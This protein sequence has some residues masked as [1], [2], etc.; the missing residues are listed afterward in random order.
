MPASG[1]VQHWL[2]VSLSGGPQRDCG[3]ASAG[4]GAERTFLGTIRLDLPVDTLCICTGP[5]ILTLYGNPKA[6]RCQQ[7]H[8]QFV[9]RHI[10]ERRCSVS[11]SECSS[12]GRSISI[13]ICSS[14]AGFFRDSAGVY[15]QYG[16][17]FEEFAALCGAMAL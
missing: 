7:E 10:W 14:A 6:A 4:E 12:N 9:E 16:S 8:V 13:G 17:F 2:L 5:V 11:T 3:E 1:P 15:A